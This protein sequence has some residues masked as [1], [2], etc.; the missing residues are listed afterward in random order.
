M[1][2]WVGILIGLMLILAILVI[3]LGINHSNQLK[4]EA[5]EYSPPGSIVE[6]NGKRFHVFTE[7]DGDITLVFMSG[8]GTSS[9]TLDFKPVWSRMKDGFRIAVIERAGYGWSEISKSPKDMETMLEETRQVLESSGQMPPYVLIPHSMAGLEALY[10]AQKYPHEVSA[11][12]GLDPC[13]PETVQLLPKPS[14]IQLNLM[15]FISRIGLS[16]L[17]PKSEMEA[18]LPLLKS[19]DLSA[20]EKDQYI[21]IFYSRSFTMDMLREVDFLAAN[22]EKVAQLEAPV[23]TPMY[24]FISND[25]EDI[26]PGWREALTGYIAKI[27]FSKTMQLAASHYVHHD[28]ADIIAEEAQAFLAD[29]KK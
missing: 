26:A 16:R 10:W 29:I 4:K 11:I 14:R 28:H 8:H 23:K 6:V 19:D 21:A 2:I 13:T 5:K 18:N 24:F 12:I 9:P 25:Q 7:G 27:E 3:T 1:K 17:M 22:A 20:E 15:Y